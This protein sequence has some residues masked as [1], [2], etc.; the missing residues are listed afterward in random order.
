[1]QPTDTPAAGYGVVTFRGRF[2]S[3]E[4]SGPAATMARVLGSAD[5][6]LG[7]DLFPAETT[8]EVLPITHGERLSVVSWYRGG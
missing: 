5:H 8:H 7:C 2:V 1:M 3:A 4:A 6:E